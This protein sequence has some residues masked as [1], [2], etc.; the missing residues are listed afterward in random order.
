MITWCGRIKDGIKKVLFATKEK[1]M[2]TNDK[3]QVVINFVI[4]LFEAGV[5]GC[6]CLDP[7]CRHF[8]DEQ[9]RKHYYRSIHEALKETGLSLDKIRLVI[10]FK[11]PTG[12]AEMIQGLS[13]QTLELGQ[14]QYSNC[15][16]PLQIV[17]GLEDCLGVTAVIKKQG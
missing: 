3:R 1:I 15:H 13:E 10:S 16:N 4:A 2:E 7:V 5:G 8:N 14:W 12:D 17:H 6:I 9:Q 11:A